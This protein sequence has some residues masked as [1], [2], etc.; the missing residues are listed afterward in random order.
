MDRRSVS[1]FERCN[2]YEILR[3]GAK[4]AR[5]ESQFINRASETLARSPAA[6][7]RCIA[8]ANVCAAAH[9]RQEPGAVLYDDGIVVGGARFGAVSRPCVRVEPP[10]T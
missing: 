5:R 9:A 8:R 2:P 3:P 4:N 1:R 7:L 10:R 6:V